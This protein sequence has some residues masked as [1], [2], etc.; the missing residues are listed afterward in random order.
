MPNGTGGTAGVSSA[1]FTAACV[2]KTEQYHTKE[3]D[4]VI[5]FQYWGRL[6]K[7][8]SAFGRLKKIEYSGGILCENHASQRR[9][10]RPVR[11]VY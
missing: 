5:Q 10:M 7:V 6:P 3:D 4:F 1:F 11:R 8:S 9:E 2:N